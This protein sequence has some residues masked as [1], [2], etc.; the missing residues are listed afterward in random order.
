[1]P[2]IR[3][4]ELGVLKRVVNPPGTDELAQALDK[5]ETDKFHAVARYSKAI[6]HELAVVELPGLSVGTFR[7][8]QVIVYLVRVRTLAEILVP[9]LADHS[10]GEIGSI[11]DN[12][13]KVELL[14]DVPG[15]RRISGPVEL[16]R[17]DLNWIGSNFLRFFHL[18]LDLN[19]FHLAVDSLARCHLEGSERMMV[20]TLWS[21]IEALFS[22]DHELR[23]RLSS[24]IASVLEPSGE[25]RQNLYDRVKQL[26]DIRST[27]VHGEEISKKKLVEHIKEVRKL[28][29]RLLC[30][31]TEKGKVP[32][33]KEIEKIVF[34]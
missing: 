21:G 22:I 9:A 8:G 23:F 6:S 16:T 27:V 25:I 13:C 18:Y 28:L 20:A 4:G 17:A 31:F 19:N 12:S 32:N 26:Y 15:A 7:L 34:T 2:E 30:K 5:L 33:Q 1:M 10:W 3:L 24:Y 11:K 29:S 14:E